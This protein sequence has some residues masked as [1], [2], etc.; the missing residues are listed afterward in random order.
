MRLS[1]ALTRKS[2]HTFPRRALTIKAEVD[3]LPEIKLLVQRGV[4][5]SILSLSAVREEKAAG[6]VQVRSIVSANIRRTV[7]LCQAKERPLTHAAEAVRQITLRVAQ[8]L[9]IRQIWPGQPSS[10]IGRVNLAALKRGQ[11]STTQIVSH[12]GRFLEETH[13][14]EARS[15]ASETDVHWRQMDFSSAR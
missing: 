1:V 15:S 3:A 9:V 13:D 14:R 5:S 10:S 4:G 8:D 7:R 6:L 11:R 2:T 12:K